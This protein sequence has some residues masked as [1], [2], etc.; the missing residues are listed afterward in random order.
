MADYLFV[1]GKLA[2]DALKD[3]LEAMAPDF[4]YRI[5]RLDISVAALMDA[6]WIAGHL[7]GAEG[8]DTVMVSGWVQGD[9]ALIE[10]RV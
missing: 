7:D 6:G 9:P 5:K 1:S 10:E 2:A 8:C 4:D 3:T